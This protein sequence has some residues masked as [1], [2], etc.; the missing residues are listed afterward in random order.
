MYANRVHRTLH[1]GA[2]RS[3]KFAVVLALAGVLGALGAGSAAAAAPQGASGTCPSPTLSQPFLPWNDSSQY[4]LAPAGSMENDPTAAGWQLSGG[5]GLA[6]G[7]EPFDVTGNPLDSS[8][9]ALPAGSSATTPWICATRSDPYIRFFAQNTGSG[10]SQLEV[11]ALYY[12]NGGKLMSKNVAM[13][14]A[15]ASWSPSDQIRVLNAIK[16]GPDGTAQIAFQFTPVGSG[17]W[18]M[19]DLYIDPLKSQD[20]FSWGGGGCG[21]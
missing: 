11:D 12:N 2:F 17:S 1:R 16:P 18:S 7:N 14:S 8:S 21:W 10:S 13:L 6:N 3:G 4:F 5:A 19:D 20:G 9:L 15:G